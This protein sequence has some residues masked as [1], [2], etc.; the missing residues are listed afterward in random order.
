M[1]EPTL[2]IIV[3]VIVAVIFDY[4]NGWNDSANAIA[5]VV[6]TR[7]LS[8]GR[9]VMLAAVLN[10]GGALVS[11]KV[12]KTI[13]AGI[14]DPAMISQTAV[15]ACMFSAAA[16]VWI[17]TRAGLPISGSHSLIG[18]LVGAAVAKTSTL[19]V[20]QV[21]GMQKVLLAMLISPLLG[22]AIS[23]LL[24]LSL[25]WLLR[26]FSNSQVQRSFGKLQLISVSLMA[27]E[28]GRNDAQKVMGVITLA[29]IAGGFQTS[30]DPQ[31]W[32][33]LICGAA[34]ALGTAA[35]G[36]KVIRTLG[37][38]LIKIQPVHGFAAETGASITLAIAASI[39][40]PVST[41]HT[42]TGAIMGVGA[43]RRLSAVRW[44]LGSKIMLAW[45]LT[46]PTTAILGV[47]FYWVL[48]Y[49]GMDANV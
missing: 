30:T 38:N 29:L 44:G 4:M 28:H 9:A 12:A 17:C 46:L 24:M 11:V 39:G 21:A 7:V 18:A 2:L 35:G 6:S 37:S 25:L 26:G 15:L 40:A 32:V 48:H 33:K 49:F 16:W 19:G 1:A 10:L 13:T 36:W 14:V 27:W 3:V 45:G 5:T 41:T 23:F 43:T 42:I 34:M 8:P 31:L 47:V 22:F 20:V